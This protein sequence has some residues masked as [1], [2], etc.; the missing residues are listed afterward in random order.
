MTVLGR[1][2]RVFRG[3][4]YV[5]RF[6]FFAS[7]CYCRRCCH[8][9]YFYPLLE[10][11]NHP[12]LTLAYT[13]SKS[14][15]STL[16]SIVDGCGKCWWLY[17]LILC[18]KNIVNV[19]QAGELAFKLQRLRGTLIH[20]FVRS[21][22]LAHVFQAKFRTTTAVFAVLGYFSKPFAA[23]PDY[24]HWQRG[25]KSAFEEELG[26]KIVETTERLGQERSIWSC[27]YT[28]VLVTAC[29]CRKPRLC[30]LSPSS[31]P[32]FWETYR[33]ISINL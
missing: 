6:S 27:V 18:S 8:C 19:W 5:D 4:V 20:S 16:L 25:C 33:P 9:Y 21:S 22:L 1:K 24:L 10:I 14:H 12:P 31:R 11:L 23:L 26:V 2:K 13:G 32:F 30:N 17:V 15:L 28:C 29:S 7:K 3:N